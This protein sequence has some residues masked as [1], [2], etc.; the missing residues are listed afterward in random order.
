M[1][2]RTYDRRPAP[3]RF[4]S[5]VDK[6]SGCWVWTGT[7]DKDG[8]GVFGATVNGY[9]YAR[10]PRFS[11]WLATGQ[12]PV[13]LWVLHRCDNPPCVRPDHL[14]IGDA[15]RNN[16]DMISKGRDRYSVGDEHWSRRRPEL[17]KRGDSHPL[18]ERPE[19]I[20]RG[21]DWR[22]TKISDAQVAEIRRRWNDGG[23]L[24]KD[25]ATEY[26][27]SFQHVSDICRG[28]KRSMPARVSTT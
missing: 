11:Y 19:L 2:K 14:F 13:G 25:L 18:R 15:A 7:C 4:W 17:V 5:N 6:S 16:A 8:Y 3:I 9:H 26:G 20:K 23:V 12:H 22:Y 10:A 28:K 27:V 21:D 24:Q 1:A